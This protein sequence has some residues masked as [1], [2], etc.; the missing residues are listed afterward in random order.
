MKFKVI[1]DRIVNASSG[2]TSD[3]IIRLEG[4]KTKDQ[5]PELIK[6]YHITTQRVETILNLK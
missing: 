1:E 2:A 3:Q 5:Y 6:G 4:L